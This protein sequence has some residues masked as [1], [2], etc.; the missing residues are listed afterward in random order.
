MARVSPRALPQRSRVSWR[1]AARRSIAA[2]VAESRRAGLSDTQIARA[3][4]DSYPWGPRRWWPYRAWCRA[5]VDVFYAEGLTHVLPN[6]RRR[7]QPWLPAAMK[8]QLAR[9]MAIRLGQQELP[10]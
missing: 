6:R 10:L 2:V 8:A 4:R 1:L 5:R 7:I 3:V 9:D